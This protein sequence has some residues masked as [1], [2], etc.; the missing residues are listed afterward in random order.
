MK[1]RLVAGGDGQDKE[2]YENLSSPAVCNES[3]SS[4]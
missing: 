2:L 4:Q 1:A 3:R